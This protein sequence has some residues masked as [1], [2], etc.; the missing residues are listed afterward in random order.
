M[1]LLGLALAGCSN[2]EPIYGASSSGAMKDTSSPPAADCSAY[3][4]AGEVWDCS[5]L[6][7]CDTSESSV[8]LRVACCECD[9]SLCS[10]ACDTGDSGTP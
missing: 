7:A 6:D 10:D 1:W 3:P 5:T 4:Y 2:L 9:V 8:P